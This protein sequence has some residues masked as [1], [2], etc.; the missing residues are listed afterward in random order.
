[1]TESPRKLAYLDTSRYG[2]DRKAGGTVYDAIVVGGGPSGSTA[3]R[4]LARAGYR[5]ALVE[6]GGRI[7]PCGGAIPPRAIE[8]FAIPH[9]QIKAR[10]HSARMIAPSG[11]TV[12]MPIDNGYVG[13][14]DREEFDEW[15]RERAALSG[16]ERIAATFEGFEDAT[17]AMRTVVLR[18]KGED[19]ERLRLSARLVIGADG[20]KSLV[21]RLALPKQKPT[22]CVFA[23]HEI[24][25]ST[26]G[27]NGIERNP[28]NRCDVYYQG[29]ISP[30]FYGW[31]FPHGET[32]S[33]GTGTARKGYGLRKAVSDLRDASGYADARTIRREGAPIPL[34]PLKRWDDGRNVLLT[35]DAAGVVAPASGEGIYYALECGRM[36]A[37]AGE[38][39]LKT[40]N[41]KCLSAARREFL[42]DHG[43][44]FAI[45]GLLQG[46]WYRSDWLRERFVAICKDADVQRMT[47]E[48]YMHKKLTRESPLAHG[49]ILMQN[50]GHYFGWRTA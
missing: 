45:L 29:R 12:D 22:P 37:D 32:T 48:S 13:M 43:T 38:K 47:W 11:K 15:L 33:I 10:I 2:T 17:G 24:V 35:G 30:D 18:R 26:G 9:S 36:V 16:A 23:Y 8:D 19:T 20:A 39:F 44:V 50:I 42:G 49:R 3:A 6:R 21:A 34:K 46:V 1:M 27:E 41:P 14:V 31:V 5:T 28:D 40:G 25:E 7:K 4:A